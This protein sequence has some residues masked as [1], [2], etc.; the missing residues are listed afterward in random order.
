M[1]VARV[2]SVLLLTATLCAQP[3]A[4]QVDPLN[5]MIGDWSV[6]G[7][8]RGKPVHHII[9]AEW[10]LD[11]Q[12]VRLHE[13]TDDGAPPSESRYDAY[14]FIGYDAVSER[15]VAHLF[16]IFGQRFSETLGY[17]T[18]FRDE[19]RFVYEYP[20]GPFHTTYRWLEKDGT[21]EWILEQKEKDTWAPFAHFKLTRLPSKAN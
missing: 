11:R 20:D 5:K 7:D 17:G 10:I 16:D 19:I 9:S 15:Y 2:V 1:R 12:F 14:W 13:K 4:P 21:W 3:A 6:E 18:R 8:V